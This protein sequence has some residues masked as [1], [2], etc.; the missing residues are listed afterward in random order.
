MKQGLLFLILDCFLIISASGQRPVQTGSPRQIWLGGVDPVAQSDRHTSNPAD[1]MDLFK[2]DAAWSTGAAATNVFKVGTAFILRG[3]DDQVRTVLEGLKSRHIALAVE[4]GVLTGS[5]TCGKGIE[6]FGSPAAA[7][8]LCKKIKRLGG[9]LDYIAMDEPVIWGHEKQGTNAKGLGRCCQYPIPELAARA[10]VKIATLQRYFPDV[11]IGLIDAV[12]G[13]YPHLGAD[14]VTFIDLLQKTTGL[15]LAFMH[16]DV[17]WDSDWQPQMELLVKRLRDRHIRVGVVF[18]GNEQSSSDR[19]WIEQ[20]LGHYKDIT[21]NPAT[22][23]D[24]LVFQ[25]WSPRPAKMLPE[26]DPGA[27]TYVLKYAVTTGK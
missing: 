15:K 22:A 16:M 19:Q 7:E 18:D 24:D 10:S 3:T 17:A 13:R 4:F 9:Q 1:Y 21:G 5:D 12:S 26:T 14:I 11:K 6:G 25:T 27:W 20:A 2:P 8:V 23:V